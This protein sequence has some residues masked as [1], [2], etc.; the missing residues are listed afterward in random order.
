MAYVAARARKGRVA[1]GPNGSEA[2]RSSGWAPY[3]APMLAF[4]LTVEIGARLPDALQ[5][6]LLV[7]RVAAPLGFL[8][9]FLRRRAYPELAGA[10]WGSGWWLAD[11]AVGLAGAAL[12]IVPFLVWDALRPDTAGFDPGQLGAEGAWL[13]LS[14]RAIGYAAVTPFVE[15]LFVRSWLIRY[16]D[17]FDRRRDFR[18]V[19][20]AR[21]TWRS[22]LV[23]TA[24]FVFTH[25]QWEWGVMLAWTLLTMGWFYWRGH[26]AP[27]VLA[28]AVTNAAILGF[29]ALFD[30][31]FHDAAG[32][33]ISLWFF[34]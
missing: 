18:A 19:P 15:E 10:R 20:I 13:A 31:R 8:V 11:V 25:A 21:F 33:P 6:L 23:V 3:W 30:G 7:V 17:V 4:L 14:L 34:L 12:W 24:Y 29:V 5:P 27:L 2:K 28:H 22:F 16:V 32:D 26:L 1:E 9:Y